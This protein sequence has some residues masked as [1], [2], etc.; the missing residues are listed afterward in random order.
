MNLSLL[1][2]LDESRLEVFEEDIVVPESRKVYLKHIPKLNTLYI[3]DITLIFD[4]EPLTGQALFDYRAEYDYVAAKGILIFS[5]GDVGSTFHCR[6]VPVASRVDASVVNELIT[7]GNTYDGNIWTKADLL[8]SSS[9]EKVAWNVIKDRPLNASAVRDGLLSKEDKQKLDLIPSPLQ[10]KP[11]GS[12]TVGDLTIEPAT[13][14]GTVTFAETDTLTPV[15]MENEDT[16]AKYLEFRVNIAAVTKDLSMY[17][18]A[19]KGTTGTPSDLNRYVTNDD[20]RMTDARNPLAHKHTIEDVL[21]LQSSLDDKANVQHR[22]NVEDIDGLTTIQGPQGPQ[23]EKAR[24]VTR[25]TL[26]H[27]ALRVKKA[28]RATLARKALRVKKGSK[29]TRRYL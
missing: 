2:N 1:Y 3:T 24:R 9:G 27:K 26:A 14:G 15:I 28:I 25:A 17:M 4:G 16:G 23:G 11:I 22:H 8:D 7:F 10:V 20:P 29:V 18:E 6:Y 21:A 13:W 19:L 5:Q 12:I